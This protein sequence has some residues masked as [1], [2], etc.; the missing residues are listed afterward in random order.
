V[1]DQVAKLLDNQQLGVFLE[2]PLLYRWTEER[3]FSEG[4]QSVTI[5]LAA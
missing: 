5:D 4:L 2:K 1:K 3:D